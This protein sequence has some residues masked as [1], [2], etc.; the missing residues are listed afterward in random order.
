MGFASIIASKD[1]IKALI[2]SAS[3]VKAKH[4]DFHKALDDWWMHN[5][6]L[7]EALPVSQ[8]VFRLRREF[9]TSIAEALVPQGMLDLHQIRG[10]FAA[11]MN[12]MAA[13]FK[14]VAASGWSAELIPEAEILQSQFP[15]VLE[16]IERDQARM[17]ELEGLFAAAEAEDADVD[18]VEN[19]VLPK[20]V[21]K[22]LRAEKK[23]IGGE[24]TGLKKD[25]KAYQQDIKRLNTSASLFW[26]TDLVD[27]G[28]ELPSIAWNC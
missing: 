23:A 26:E 9:L 24:L 3:G 18:D 19:G 12:R 1:H 8:N 22:S 7:I 21:V 28:G 15:D 5:M 14:S 20:E 11:Y 25:L 13:D 4:E 2:Q 6:P 17:A 16:Q 27:I 10:A